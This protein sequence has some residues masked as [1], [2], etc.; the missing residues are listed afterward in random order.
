MAGER[1]PGEPGAGLEAASIATVARL[2]PGHGVPLLRDLA[3]LAETQPPAPPVSWTDANAIDLA[4]CLAAR[5]RRDALDGGMNLITRHFEG[6]RLTRPGTL[7]SGVR[8]Q[9]YASA[10][11]YCSAIGW[12]QMGARFSVQAL[13]FADTLSLRYRA[14]SLAALAHALNGEYQSAESD[15]ATAEELFGNEGWP[16]EETDY[17]LLLAHAYV[18]AARIDVPRLRS[19]STRM[20]KAR[21]DDP[22]TAFSADAMDAVAEMLSGDFAAG[23]AGSR[24]L[25]GGTLRHSSHRMVRHSLVCATSDLLVAQGEHRQALAMLEP[26]ESPEGHSICFSMQRAA[27][28]LHLGRERDLLNETEACAASGTDHCLR[29]LIPVLTRRALALNRLGHPRRARDTME[30]ALLLIARTGLP[31][32]PFL[33][34]PRHETQVLVDIAMDGHDELLAVAPALRAALAHAALPDSE[35]VATAASASLTPSER[36]LASLLAT[37]V[38][39][40]EIARE[41]RVSLN[42]VKSHVRSI[43][44]KLDVRTRAEAVERLTRLER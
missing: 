16:H 44:H 9:L 37:P 10:G 41:R 15:I 31:A 22:H 8:S 25:L 12:P 34:L 2:A 4:A 7:S 6:G 40:A 39:L 26:Y 17:L 5:A 24:R 32:A 43:Y 27:A 11:E 36:A 42:T 21:S 13:L 30:A 19:A 14:L 38:S 3:L 28:L 35:R 29:T 20:A 23:R 18:A 1:A 33:M